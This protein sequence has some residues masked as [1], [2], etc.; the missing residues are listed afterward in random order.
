MC[1]SRPRKLKNRNSIIGYKVAI[2]EMNG[3][4]TPL[5]RDSYEKRQWDANYPKSFHACSNLKGVLELLYDLCFRNFWSVRHKSFH[6]YV[7]L[8]VELHGDIHIDDDRTLMNQIAGTKQVI[9]QEIPFKV[10]INMK[11]I[12]IHFKDCVI[13]K[14]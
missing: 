5:F 10:N 14:D 3:E 2:K 8:V 9:L 4:I 13:I 7:L 6:E 1:L 11:E 12:R